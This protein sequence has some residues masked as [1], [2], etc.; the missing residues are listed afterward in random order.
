MSNVQKTFS[1]TL[2][3]AATTLVSSAA[4]AKD[5]ANS[6]PSVTHVQRKLV[7]RADQGMDALRSYVWQTSIVYGI[8]MTDVKQSLD[9]WRAAIAC[10]EQV[11]Q[12]AANVEVAAKAA[13][14]GNR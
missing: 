2:F 13:N 4:F 7:E 3:I 14:E 9:A 8:K 12:G 1:V 10:Q 5:D 6:C 11:A